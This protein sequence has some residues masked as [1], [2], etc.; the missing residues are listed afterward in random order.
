MKGDE[1]M[2][3]KDDM[4]Y[5]EISKQF[6]EFCHTK[7][8]A[9]KFRL[10]F[11]D[12]ADNAHRQREADKA[13]FAEVKRQSEEANPEFT[14][15]LRTKGV[16]AKVKLVIENFRKGAKEASAK[17]AVAVDEISAQTKANVAK[18]QK[19][20]SR[21]AMGSSALNA[22]PAGYSADQL[23]KEFNEFLKMKGLDGKFV[24]EVSEE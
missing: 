7:G 13:N 20:V 5:E 8:I 17:T 12:M 6:E 24:V 10:A 16:K 3:R 19:S 1:K 9:A 23:S 11:S 18:A 4:S 2:E 15:F 21:P 22:D 14:E